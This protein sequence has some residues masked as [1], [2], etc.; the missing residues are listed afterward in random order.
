MRGSGVLA[1]LMGFLRTR[2]PRF[3]RIAWWIRP[4]SG[5]WHW[6]ITRCLLLLP[7][8]SSCVLPT[9]GIRFRRYSVL[10]SAEVRMTMR[11]FAGIL[12]TS[13][14]CNA[15]FAQSTDTAPATFEVAD[16]HVSP[17][18]LFPFMDGGYLRGDRYVLRQATMV[19]LIST[20]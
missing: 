19:D 11:A 13:L 7:D 3:H 5:P 4:L 1:A 9:P 12:L 10:V 8:R 15:A 16:V 6:Q 18:R 20:A 17:H 14:L 2:W